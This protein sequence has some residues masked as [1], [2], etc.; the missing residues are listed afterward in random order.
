MMCSGC[1]AWCGREGCVRR[2]VTVQVTMSLERRSWTQRTLC[3]Q[4]AHYGRQYAPVT[5]DKRL[6]C[7]Y[8]FPDRPTQRANTHTMSTTPP[9]SKPEEI[10]P[11]KRQSLCPISS[12]VKASIAHNANHKHYRPSIQNFQ[13]TRNVHHL[14]HGIGKLVRN[15]Q[16]EKYGPRH[17]YR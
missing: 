5:H 17:R 11:P 10:S 14:P 2:L 3:C 6:H 16:N 9:S 13:R 15:K 4:H 1:W 8:P 7:P 12:L